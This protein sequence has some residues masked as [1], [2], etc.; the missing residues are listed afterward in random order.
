MQIYSLDIYFHKS[1]RVVASH[2]SILVRSAQYPRKH[3]QLIIFDHMLVST[4]QFQP[5]IDYEITTNSHHYMQT[6]YKYPHASF[7]HIRF[8]YAS[9]TLQ[10]RII[11]SPFVIVSVDAVL[12]N[13]FARFDRCLNLFQSITEHWST[14]A[15]LVYIRKFYLLPFLSFYLLPFLSFY[16]PTF[17]ASVSFDTEF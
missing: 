15:K 7:V 12:I 1:C 11:L 3:V 2:P 9:S 13:V 16:R 6:T 8:K 4:N 14:G 17:L 10:V 5:M